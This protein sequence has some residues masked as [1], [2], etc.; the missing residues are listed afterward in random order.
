MT[1]LRHDDPPRDMTAKSA[2]RATKPYKHVTDAE[3]AQRRKELE[4]E[5]KAKGEAIRKAEWDAKFGGRKLQPPFD[6]FQN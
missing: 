5:A 3:K 1:K 2:S 4:N 6:V